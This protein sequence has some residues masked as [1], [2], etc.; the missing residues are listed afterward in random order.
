M[1]F[2]CLAAV[3][4]TDLYINSCN[5]LQTCGINAHVTSILPQ[6]KFRIAAPR[7]LTSCT[8]NVS[9][10]AT[11]DNQPNPE[12]PFGNS[13]GSPRP[14][15]G[16]ER[17]L[18]AGSPIAGRCSRRRMN[19][20]HLRIFVA[21]VE[22]GSLS[23]ASKVLHGSPPA[24]SARLKELED[25]FGV[26]LFE[27]RARGLRLTEEGHEFVSHAYG[28]LKQVE[29]AKAAMSDRDRP[30][31]G[32]VRFGV[33][34]SLVD[35]LTVQL[36]EAARARMPNVRLRV[37][38]A[39][40]GNIAAWL[41]DGALDAAIQ[42]SGRPITDPGVTLQPI[43]E[44]EL[45]IA[46]YNADVVAP[47]LTAKGAIPIEQ[48]RHLPLVL[49]GPEHE[50]RTLVETVAQ[51]VNIPLNVVIEIDSPLRIFEFVRRGYGV[52]I[53]AAHTRHFG[54]STTV[55]KRA[56]LTFPAI[57]PL[58]RTIYRATPLNRPSS[59]ATTAVSKLAV[60]ILVSQ[61][62]TNRWK[63]RLL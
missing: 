60:E 10:P 5:D 6:R 17:T 32:E 57:E 62:S 14:E 31:V 23:A 48:L 53:C 18:P 41:R 61:I 1:D 26:A 59:R 36:I 8:G 50:L 34:A 38:E 28:I 4:A 58:K 44:E 30:T 46:T 52:T 16:G 45:A 47:F 63:A 20:Q 35:L 49:P 7:V 3:Q 55:F 24:L 51:R 25:E 40:S 15:S 39:H 54:F 37:I 19:L 43:A 13:E 9:N 2:H 33:P 42:F 11:I 22:S 29:D 56:L 12:Y 21:I 27:R